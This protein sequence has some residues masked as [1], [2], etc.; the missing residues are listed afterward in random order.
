MINEKKMKILI[1]FSK[2]HFRG[3]KTDGVTS[4]LIENKIVYKYVP[5][6]V[7][8]DFQVLDLTVAKWVQG[9]MMDKF[10]KWF[11]ET[12]RKELDAKSL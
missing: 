11:A 12:L 10:N 7:T 4:L 1:N 9:I 3:Q 5:S 8:A 2:G 6:N